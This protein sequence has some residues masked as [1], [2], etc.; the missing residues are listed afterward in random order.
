MGD[1][2]TLCDG[3]DYMCETFCNNSGLTRA[4]MTC[5]K[6]ALRNITWSTCCAFVW[7]K[8]AFVMTRVTENRIVHWMGSGDK[9]IKINRSYWEESTVSEVDDLYGLESDQSI[10]INDAF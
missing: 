2:A 9:F 1:V 10:F 5:K 6:T 4:T 8:Y 7:G 3:K